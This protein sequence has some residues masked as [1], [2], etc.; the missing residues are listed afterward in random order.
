M[1]SMSA[2]SVGLTISMQ[3]SVMY[4]V[5]LGLISRMR[6]FGAIGG[7]DEIVAAEVEE[8]V[9]RG[10]SIAPVCDVMRL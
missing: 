1:T 4:L 5:E 7:G 3:L 9:R 8:G 6:R 10:G 2:G